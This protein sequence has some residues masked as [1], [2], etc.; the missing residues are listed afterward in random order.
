MVD[1]WIVELEHPVWLL[2]PAG[3]CLVVETRTESVCHWWLIRLDR[4]EKRKIADQAIDAR[5]W[6]LS[7][8]C[9]NFAIIT[10]YDPEANGY[11]A[12][13]GVRVFR[14][15]TGE[16]IITRPDWQFR[17]QLEQGWIE[18]IDSDKKIYVSMV[19]GEIVG[20]L[21]QQPASG[22]NNGENVTDNSSMVGPVGVSVLSGN[23]KAELYW[24][25]LPGQPVFAQIDLNVEPENSY[26]IYQKWCLF[27]PRPSQLGV[28]EIPI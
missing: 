13:K 2:K 8:A 17:R 4:R 18:I 27:Q 25:F 7:A 23:Q 6:H 5:L 3:D 26:W 12:A 24:N 15:E 11:P 19:T 16:E 22:E 10:G 1:N 14:L 20:N 28:A 21:E 9:C